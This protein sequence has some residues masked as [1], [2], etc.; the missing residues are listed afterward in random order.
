MCDWVFSAPPEGRSG[1]LAYT[2]VAVPY[3][4]GAPYNF[5]LSPAHQLSSSYPLW[6]EPRGQ[7]NMAECRH[8]GTSQM[9]TQHGGRRLK[10][11]YKICLLGGRFACNNATTFSYSG[12]SGFCG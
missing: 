11:F 2:F 6:Q 7:T 4:D 1:Q 3:L 12:L 9:D 5:Q 8:I 10:R